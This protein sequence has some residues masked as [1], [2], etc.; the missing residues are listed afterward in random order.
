MKVKLNNV[1]LA[2]P[3]LWKPR[4]F[5]GEGEA[6]YGATLLF[7]PDHPG[8]KAVNEAIDAVA[9]EKWE[10]KATAELKKLRAADKVCLHDGDAKEDLDGYA[11]NLYVSARASVKPSVFDGNLNPLEEGGGKPYAGCYVNAVIEIWAQD[12][13]WGKRV[14]ATLK[15][16]QFLCDGDAFA[17]SGPATADDFDLVEAEALV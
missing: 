11:G 4:A 1:R 17:G 3:D 10:D 6:K 15:G 14:N 7:A 5:N 16:V 12:N 9:R 2:F 13:A 8:A